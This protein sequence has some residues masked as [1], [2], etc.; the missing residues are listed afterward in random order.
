MTA[1]LYATE[2]T[3]EDT[4]KWVDLQGSATNIEA[5]RAQFDEQ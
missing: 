4:L 2:D 5:L 3:A 1:Y